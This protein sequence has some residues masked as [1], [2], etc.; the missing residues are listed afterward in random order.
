M[1][2][3]QHDNYLSVVVPN[4]PPEVCGGVGQGMLGNDEL[5]TPEVTLKGEMGAVSLSEAH[6]TQTDGCL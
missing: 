3:R 2:I 1:V 6:S 5:I 4:H